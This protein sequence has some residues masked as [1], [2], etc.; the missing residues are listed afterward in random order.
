MRKNLL[1][2][3]LHEVFL[4][5]HLLNFSFY[6]L[7]HLHLLP[8]RDL[9]ICTGCGTFVCRP[10]CN[11]INTYPFPLFSTLCKPEHPLLSLPNV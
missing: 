8:L 9:T 10:G 5:I 4:L 3:L 7:G 11:P 6:T 1:D 2:D